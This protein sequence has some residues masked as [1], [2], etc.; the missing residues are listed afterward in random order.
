MFRSPFLALALAACVPVTSTA[1][2]VSFHDEV[3]LTGVY[4]RFQVEEGG[5]SVA[6]HVLSEPRDTAQLWVRALTLDGEGDLLSQEVLPWDD[7]QAHQ[8]HDVRRFPLA[9]ECAQVVWRDPF[10]ERQIVLGAS[11]SCIG[12]GEVHVDVLDLSVLSRSPSLTGLE[13]LAWTYLAEVSASDLA[14]RA[15]LGGFTLRV[16]VL[17]R[18]DA[19]LASQQLSFSLPEP[20]RPALLEVPFP[21]DTE[22]GDHTRYEVLFDPAG[23]WPRLILDR[24]VLDGDAVSDGSVSGAAASRPEG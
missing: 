6:V 17:D 20:H 19:A 7:L 24:R 16:E 11:P 14:G 13:R 9:G 10:S 2:A 22:R 12:Q 3:D 15:P 21:L 23:D 5:V 4:D 1:P 8:D 18:R